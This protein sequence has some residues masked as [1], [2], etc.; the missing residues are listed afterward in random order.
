MARFKKS[1][2]RRSRRPKPTT[3]ITV[4]RGGVRL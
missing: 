1:R 3:T 4:P 2:K